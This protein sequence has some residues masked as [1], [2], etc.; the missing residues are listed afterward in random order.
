MIK[1]ARF[2]IVQKALWLD[3]AARQIIDLWR[4]KQTDVPWA[5]TSADDGLEDLDEGYVS[6]TP[7]SSPA[8]SSMGGDPQFFRA[9]R[10]RE[11]SSELS[12]EGFGTPVYPIRRSPIPR[13]PVSSGA[14]SRRT[15]SSS[16]MST[17]SRGS[18]RTFPEQVERMVQ[19]FMIRG[20]HGPMQTLLD[21]RTYGL[22]IHF[23]STAPGHVAWMGADEILY[24]DIQFTMGG[25]GGLCMGWWARQKNCCISCCSPRRRRRSHGRSSMMTPRRARPAGAFSAI[26]ARHGRWWGGGG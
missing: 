22:K 7:S 24:K 12:S 5:L 16:P 18:G 15:P 21:W 4:K 23:N 8:P 10:S 6:G 2:F 13:R 11:S 14:P 20:T 26:R 3:P 1:I 9:D 25:F 17:I 19:R